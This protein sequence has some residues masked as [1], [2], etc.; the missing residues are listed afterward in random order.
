[1]SFKNCLYKLNDKGDV[2][3]NYLNL[4]MSSPLMQKIGFHFCIERGV[5]LG[6]NPE[7]R[8]KAFAF[9]KSFMKKTLTGK[10]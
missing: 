2:L 8:K 9:S 1:M 10:N 3:M 6:G 4:P 7:R 5:N